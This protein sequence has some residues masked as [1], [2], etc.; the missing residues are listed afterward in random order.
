MLTL[1]S[2]RRAALVLA[3]GTAA[4][5]SRA[6]ADTPRPP[7]CFGG[8]AT[9]LTTGEKGA[10][11]AT[12]VGDSL[13]WFTNDVRRMVLKTKAIS[14]LEYFC[15]GSAL[16]FSDHDGCS[17]RHLSSSSTCFRGGVRNGRSGFIMVHR[18]LV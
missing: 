5:A 1:R 12:L 6:A 9:A 17:S 2:V 15:R 14:S 18:W 13:Y 11:N 10:G 7:A 3:A 4:F 8:P 16:P